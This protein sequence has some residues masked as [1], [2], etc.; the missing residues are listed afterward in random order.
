MANYRNH[1]SWA[2]NSA[3]EC[4]LHTVE[5]IG[6]NPIAPTNLIFRRFNHLELG[7][8]LARQIF[9]PMPARWNH[10]VDSEAGFIRSSCSMYT[11]SVQCLSSVPVRVDRRGIWFG[12]M[13]HRLTN[14]M[15]FVV[16]FAADPIKKN[17]YY[18]A[19][20]CVAFCLENES[21]SIRPQHGGEQIRPN[22]A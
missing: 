21:N 19:D 15:S 17:L 7:G 22:I 9:S 16:S 14:G 3:V 18:E 5:V 20:I 10:W 12:M 13:K 4:H 11:L 6:S 1:E 8:Y 2:L